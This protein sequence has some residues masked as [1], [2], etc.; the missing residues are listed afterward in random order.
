MYVVPCNESVY[1]SYVQKT[2]KIEG[3]RDKL[4]TFVFGYHKYTKNISFASE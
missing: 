4:S 3:A 2:C 1:E